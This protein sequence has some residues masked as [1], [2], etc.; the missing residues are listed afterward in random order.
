MQPPP[1]GEAAGA[2][3]EESLSEAVLERYDELLRNEE[4][5]AL[6]GE[7]GRCDVDAKA[8]TGGG[9]TALMAS[10]EVGNLHAAR[11]LV[12]SFGANLSERDNG[13]KTVLRTAL[14]SKSDGAPAA[15]VDFL[16]R[17]CPGGPGR[18]VAESGMEEIMK[19][20]FC[21]S[22]FS[23]FFNLFSLP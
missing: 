11:L 18:L 14:L 20:C 21:S 4:V 17:V 13:Q 15:L 2:A 9:K 1:C 8:A 5:P 23:F 6:Y 16:I 3:G 7:D 19:G 10:C 22:C 12:Q